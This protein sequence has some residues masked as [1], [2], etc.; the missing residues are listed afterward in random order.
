MIG[1][2]L[3][4]SLTYEHPRNRLDK[5]RSALRRG[6]FEVYHIPILLDP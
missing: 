2:G 3:G 5:L 6:A 1:L 4:C